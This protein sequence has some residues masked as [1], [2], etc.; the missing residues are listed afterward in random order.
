MTMDTKVL[1]VYMIFI[2]LVAAIAY[3][4]FDLL[5]SGNAGLF[6]TA[7]KGLWLLIVLS[8]A[9]MAALT[10]FVIRK[11]KRSLRPSMKP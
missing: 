7:F 5:L 3:A 11:L 10:G 9:G 4:T 6:Y 8:L 2:A 1:G